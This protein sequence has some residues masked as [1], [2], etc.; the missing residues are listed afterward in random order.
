MVVPDGMGGAFTVRL[1]HLE[2]ESAISAH[3]A[4]RLPAEPE[5]IL[6]FGAAQGLEHS[7]TGFTAGFTWS[8]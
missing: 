1:G 4:F 6:D 2:G 7:Q 8:W 3:A 5:L